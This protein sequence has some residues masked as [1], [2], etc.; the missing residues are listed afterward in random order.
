MDKQDMKTLI[1]TGTVAEIKKEHFKI[2]L[3]IPVC[4]EK[5]DRITISRMVGSRWRLIGV[6]SII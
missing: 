1:E 6:S 3:K 4:A 5:I 2:K